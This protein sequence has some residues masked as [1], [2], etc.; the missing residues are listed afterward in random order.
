MN[1]ITFEYGPSML[2]SIMLHPSSGSSDVAHSLSETAELKLHENSPHHFVEPFLQSMLNTDGLLSVVWALQ[3]ALPLYVALQEIMELED[4]A[5]SGNSG[6]NLLASV[7]VIITPHSIIDIQLYFPATQ[8][9]IQLK[10]IE[11]NGRPLSVY[12]TECLQLGAQLSLSGPATAPPPM[13]S[14]LLTPMWT[15]QSDIPGVVP[16]IQG[17][18]CPIEQIGQVL[19]RIFEI[20]VNQ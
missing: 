5:L 14:S 6:N 11:T 15:Q 8:M 3:T 16:L 4:P 17:L 7:P 2:A 19:R 20:L 12:V 9:R 18:A 13:R 1:K 10:L